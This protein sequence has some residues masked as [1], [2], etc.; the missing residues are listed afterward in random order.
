MG[1]IEEQITLVNKIV[2]GEIKKSQVERELERMESKYGKECFNSYP[3]KRKLKPWTKEYLDELEMLSC[4]GASSKEFYLY[5]SEVSDEIYTRNINK[6]II[7]TV[8]V[9]I[10]LITVLSVVC[11]INS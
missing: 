1:Y 11:G 10:L 7:I 9:A 2:K 6:K 4:S 5:M 3:V 8:I